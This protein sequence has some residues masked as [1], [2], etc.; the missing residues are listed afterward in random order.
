[1]SKYVA[2]FSAMASNLLMEIVWEGG[3]VRVLG[4]HEN[5]CFNLAVVSISENVAWK[6]RLNC[7]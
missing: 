2:L 4:F 1:M 3:I 6:D 5:D 7:G